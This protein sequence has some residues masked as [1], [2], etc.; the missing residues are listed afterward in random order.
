[1][2][3]AK[4]QIA[5]ELGG[6]L[7]ADN[8]SKFM[9]HDRIAKAFCAKTCFANPYASWE[10]GINENINGLIRQF[11]PKGINFSNMSL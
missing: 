7:S 1:M 9:L 6:C 3:G 8:G 11:F 4:K 10:R 5:L 2:G